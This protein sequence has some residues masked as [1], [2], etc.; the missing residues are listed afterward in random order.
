MCFE[1]KKMYTFGNMGKVPSKAQTKPKLKKLFYLGDSVTPTREQEISA[2]SWRFSHN[3]AA[4]WHIYK[5]N[6]R[7]KCLRVLFMTTF[8]TLY[9]RLNW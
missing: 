8:Y 5:V 6:Y 4:E 2:V 3:L 1:S 9:P 7:C